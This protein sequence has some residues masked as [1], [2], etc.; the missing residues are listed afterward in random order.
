MTDV[1]TGKNTHFTNRELKLIKSGSGHFS[2]NESQKK[3]QIL[4]RLCTVLHGL[5]VSVANE[6]SFSVYGALL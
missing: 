4:L 1:E 5:C 2:S 6:T 3:S